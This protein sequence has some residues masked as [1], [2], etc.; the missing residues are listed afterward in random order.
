MAATQPARHGQQLCRSRRDRTAG[1][2]GLRERLRG[3]GL[4]AAE[5][6]ALQALLQ[7]GRRPS[8]TAFDD[9]DDPDGRSPGSRQSSALLKL[10]RAGL[11]AYAA[12]QRR[13]AGREGERFFALAPTESEWSEA[14]RLAQKYRVGAVLFGH[15]HAAR[16]FTE[17]ELVPQ[18]RHLDLADAASPAD[19]DVAEWTR[20]LEALRRDPGL[21]QPAPEDDATG[22]RLLRR[23]HVARL[24]AHPAGGPRGAL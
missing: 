12:G 3:A 9:S 10:L 1:D 24:Q 5:A 17:G 15:S 22:P 16:F 11:S 7:P 21:R 14:G 18:H 23:L 20:F 2:L 19:A 8:A 13:L 6:Q 4:D